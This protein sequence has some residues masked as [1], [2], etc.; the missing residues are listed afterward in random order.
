MSKQKNWNK[1]PLNILGKVSAFMVLPA[2]FLTSCGGGNSSADPSSS[3]SSGISQNDYY[4]PDNFVTSEQKVTTTRLVTYD[5]PSL[6]QSSSTAQV[7]VNGREV[8]V[9]DTRVNHN[10]VFS[11]SAPSTLTQAALF[12]FEGKVHVEVSFPHVESI[13]SAVVRPL[14]YGFAPTV[15]D[16]TVSFDLTHSGNYVVEV[17]DDPNTAVQ[18]FANPI[19]ENPLTKEEAEKDPN[20]IYVGPGIYDAGAF[21]IHDNTTVYLAGG[22]Y[23]YGQFLG[24]GVRN[25]TIKGRG[26]VS[27]SIYSRNSASEYTIPV[28]MRGVKG[29]TIED[30]AFF[31]PAG[32]ALHLWKCSDVRVNNV[33]IITARS[34]GDGISVQSCS[35][36]EVSGGYVRTWDDALVVKNAD[37]GTTKNI[38]IHDVVVWS[39]LAQCMEVGYETYGPTMDQISFSDITVVHAFHKAVISLHNC[40]QAKI[41]NVSYK[42]ITVEDCQTLGD[43][44]GDGENDFLVDF[45]IA[46]NDEWTKSGEKRGSVDG[47][48]IENVKVY[49]MADTVSARMRGEE[50]SSAIKNVTIK[51]LEIEGKQ[52]T[53]AAALKLATNDFVSNVH[54]ETMDKVI[55]ARLHLPYAL[56][57]HDQNVQETHVE[58]VP[59]GGMVVP[60]FAKYRGQPSFIGV[61]SSTSGT[62]SSSHGAGGKTTTPGDDGSGEFTTQNHGASLAFDGDK[63]TYYES[64][65]WKGEDN[66]FATL[67]FDFSEPT[68]VGVIRLY[69]DNGNTYSYSYGVQVWAKK[70]KTNGEMNTKYTRLLSSQIYSMTP[71]K[72]NLIDINIPTQ[73][74]GGIQLRFNRITGIMAPEHYRISQV[75]F[76]PP[77]LTYMKSIVESSEHNDVYNVERVVD[78]NATGTSYYESK[79]LPAT[80]VIDLV[81]VYRLEKLVLALPPLLTWGARTQNIEISV[82]DS[83]QKYSSSTKFSVTVPATDYLFDPASGNRVILDLD[84]VACRYLKVIINS[85]TA[86]G[87]YGAQLSEISAYGV[88]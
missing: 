25:V 65:S 1:V 70:R 74:F 50:A 66:E 17:N 6:M 88:K 21:P 75:E 33:K 62:A 47:V 79:K 37:M 4:D 29:L 82:S 39:D 69:G 64:A 78:G 15:S 12:D 36:V 8:F 44:R 42:N 13:A 34:N 52:I 63:S 77:S 24:E 51:G 5:G 31:D 38:N 41:T 87:G 40:D 18:I 9:Y 10:R 55:G 71:A 83:N 56:E 22:S 27:G 81:D 43:D 35:D 45:T 67:T 72:G 84:R 73:D 2:L 80:I 14:V 58:A 59:Q 28:V 57:L 60:E 7:K 19:E 53:S 54:F 3:S 46:Y 32:W 20:T 49:D 48:Q 85:N 26:I 11:W 16:K 76:Y 61:A 86:N 30:V 23:V 68:N